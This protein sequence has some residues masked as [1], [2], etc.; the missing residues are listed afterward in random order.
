MEHHAGAG[1]RL[2]GEP[3]HEGSLDCLRGEGDGAREEECD[4]KRAADHGTP[5]HAEEEARPDGPGADRQRKSELAPPST[6]MECPV[7]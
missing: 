6:I 5:D 3:V 4:E 7:T 1:N 2:F